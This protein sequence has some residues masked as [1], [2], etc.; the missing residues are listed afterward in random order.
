MSVDTEES[1]RK[2]QRCNGMASGQRNVAVALQLYSGL[3]S[4]RGAQWG[5]DDAD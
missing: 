4:A 3:V 2:E 1:P 5:D